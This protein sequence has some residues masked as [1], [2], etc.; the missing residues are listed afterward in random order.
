MCGSVCECERVG[1]GRL[2]RMISAL[3]LRR[4]LRVGS[5][6]RLLGLDAGALQRPAAV[7]GG[8]GVAIE[9]HAPP[10]VSSKPGSSAGWEAASL[11]TESWRRSC[12]MSTRELAY[13]AFISTNWSWS[14]APVEL[15]GALEA[16]EAVPAGEADHGS[17]SVAQG[18]SACVAPFTFMTGVDSSSN[19][20]E[21]LRGP[22]GTKPLA[23]V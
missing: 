1:V 14:D 3:A 12:V 23:G 2:W 5:A 16:E 10:C 15:G 13:R 17:P 19:S 21:K 22:D 6:S 8:D 11:D 18:S 9:C 20:A 4:C 7:F